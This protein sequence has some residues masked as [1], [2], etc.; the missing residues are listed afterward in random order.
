M[1]ITEDMAKALRVKRAKLALTKQQ[2]QE[3]IGVS[4]VTYIRLERGNW[5]AT[6]EVYQKVFSWL[7]KDFD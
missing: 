7:A 4:S 3:Q 6:K 2:V 5:N 1:Q